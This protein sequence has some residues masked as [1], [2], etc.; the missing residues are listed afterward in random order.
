[1]PYN[2]GRREAHEVG[3]HQRLDQIRL[4]KAKSLPEICSHENDG[5]NTTNV[6]PV[7]GQKDNNIPVLPYMRDCR[8]QLTICRANHAAMQRRVRVAIDSGTH[9][10][11]GVRNS[12]HHTPTV[13]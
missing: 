2:E 6:H 5:K 7:R 12:T 9:L 11:S 3:D 13:T 4:F 8:L 1:M 10:I